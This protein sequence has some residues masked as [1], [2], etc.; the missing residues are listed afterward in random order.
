MKI[1]IAGD[2]KVGMTLARRLLMEGH[3]LILIDVNQEVLEETMN[4]IDVMTIQGNAASMEVLKQADV[5]TADL[6]IAVTG[7]DEINLLCCMTAHAMNAKI[8][9]IA[10]I[11]NPEY[12][13][14]IYEMRDVFA[15]SMVVNPER[16]AALESERLLKYPGF[17]KR[18]TFAKGRVEIVEL[19]IEADSKLCNVSLNDLDSIVKCKVLICAVSRSGKVLIPDGNYVFK[20]G[21]RIFVTAPSNELTTL[22]RNLGLVKHKAKN[23]LLCGGGRVSFYLAQLLEKSGINVQLIEKDP[24]RC[25]ELASQLPKV[26]VIQGDASSLFLLES[27][28]INDCD[29]LITM[30]GLD[31]MNMIISLYGKKCDVPQI[32]TKVDHTDNS[33]IQDSLPLGSVVCPKDL[34]CTNI[35]R[36]VRA[37]QDATGAAITVHTIADGQA[38]AMEFLVDDK[39]LHCGELL[40]NLHIRKNVLIACIMHGRRTEIPNGN[41]RFE[42]GDHIIVVS[43]GEQVIKQF[44]DIF[45]D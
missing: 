30:T 43:S 19:R 31:E 6:L 12:G 44:N 3:D 36:Y 26:S 34:C 8:H 11:R 13:E 42:K 28:G 29:A 9:T 5:M 41:S 10:R 16:Q 1:L 23:V 22:L 45:E 39:T 4:R 20:E 27:E 37:M 18:D 21:D 2:G 32:I 38:E 35:V 25:I 14:Q 40:K 24:K 33:N 17:L 7:E 15:L